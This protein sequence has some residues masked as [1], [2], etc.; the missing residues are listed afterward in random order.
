MN[1]IIEVVVTDRFHCTY[2]L[3]Y[4]C[5]A[6]YYAAFW[7]LQGTNLQRKILRKDVVLTTDKYLIRILLARSA[8]S[9]TNPCTQLLLN[10]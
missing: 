3:C 7:L 6:L 9:Q 8:S 10:V 1:L 4:L 2:I 5:Y